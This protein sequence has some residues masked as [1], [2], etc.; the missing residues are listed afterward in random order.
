MND[1]ERAKS[2]LGGGVNLAIVRG[3]RQNTYSERGI[4]ALLGIAAGG[5]ELLRGAV[6]A[7]AIV[8]RAAAFLMAAG[9][10]AQVYAEVLSEG[11]TEVFRRYGI[12]YSY[13]TL[14]ERII[15]RAGTDICP[16]ERAVQGVERA[17]D[18]V[19]VLQS[20]LEALQKH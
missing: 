7:D 12:P 9:G 6:V 8:G 4:N 10:V 19:P 15:N 20:A 17:E 3:A 5:G 11:A 16:M 13:G 2:L 1:I 14:T 18:A